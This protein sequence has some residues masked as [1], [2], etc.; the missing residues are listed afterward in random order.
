MTD[1]RERICCTVFPVPVS[2]VH[3]DPKGHFDKHCLFFCFFLEIQLGGGP[4]EDLKKNKKKKAKT[5]ISPTGPYVA[6]RYYFAVITPEGFT[7]MGCREGKRTYPK[8]VPQD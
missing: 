8:Q 6:G 5:G 7:T 2:F 3:D 4:L 1:N